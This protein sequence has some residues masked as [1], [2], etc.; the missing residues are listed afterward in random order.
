MNEIETPR[1]IG[2][3]VIEV[4]VVLGDTTMPISQLLKMGRGAVIDLDAD[5]EDNVSVYAN[6]QLVAK[7]DV[8]IVGEK[9]AVSITD[10]IAIPK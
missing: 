1:A 4:S 10:T 9:I 5:I 7:G 2:D 3:V 6:N 8:V